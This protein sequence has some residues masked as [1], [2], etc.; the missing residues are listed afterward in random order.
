MQRLL[1]VLLAAVD[2]VVAAAT[3]LALLLAPLTVFWAISFGTRADWG[4]LWPT[5]ATLWQFGHG[6]PLAVSLSD[7][8]VRSTGIDSTA[9]HFVLSVPPLLF[10]AFTVI[11]AARSGRRAARAGSWITGVVSGTLVFAVISASAALTGGV[12]AI[13]VSL[14]LAILLPPLAFGCGALAG[15]IAVAWD[16]GDG[17]VIDRLQDLLDRTPHWSSVPGDAVRGAAVA[18]AGVVGAAGLALAVAALLRGGQVVA[19]FESLRADALGVVVIG[20]AQLAYVPTLAAWAVA[21]IAGP[22]FAIGTGTAVSPAGTV[23]GVVPGVP[24]FGL[25]PDNSSPWFL[26]V[27]LLPVAAGALAGWVIRSRQVSAG[28]ETGIVQRLVTVVGIAALAAGSGAL[29][30]VLSRGSLGPGRLAEA[31]ADP[32]PVA[33]ALGLEVLVG[34]AILLLAPRRHGVADEAWDEDPAVHADA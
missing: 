10:L 4:A 3:G 34:A 25:V 9:A 20:L 26:I 33:L 17:G 32:G 13:S 1:I 24:M 16:E 7:Q 12:P 8:V 11:A 22:G 2:A 21:W 14:P 15:A 5:T 6:A 28:A 29:I 19:L 18:M 23:L 30:A 27:V 31:G